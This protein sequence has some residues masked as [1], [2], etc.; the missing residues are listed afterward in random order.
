MA[1]DIDIDLLPQQE[2][3]IDNEEEDMIVSG[4]AGSGK[5]K[6]AMFKM[7]KYCLDVPGSLN[8]ATRKHGTSINFTMRDPL[9]LEL[10][11][12]HVPYNQDLT[13]NIVTLWNGTR[14]WFKSIDMLAKFRSTEFDYIWVEQAEE[15]GYY[16]YYELTMRLRGI[17]SRRQNM[18]NQ[19]ILTCTPEAESHWIYETFY[20]SGE[21][22]PI[23]FDHKQNYYLKDKFHMR[24]ER[25]KL[26]DQELYNKY[27]LGMWGKISDTIYNNWIQ[28][29]N[30]P[31]PEF[32]F[33]G[34]DWGYNNPSA[35]ILM[36]YYENNILIYNEVYK[37]EMTNTQFLNE[38]LNLLKHKGIQPIDVDMWG[39]PSEPDRMK[40]FEDAGFNMLPG[41]K[42]PLWRINTVKT[43]PILYDYSCTE[44]EKE[45]R[46]YKWEK[47]KEGKKLD[48]PIKFKDHAMDAI[49]Y[50]CVGVSEMLGLNLDLDPYGIIG[51]RSYEDLY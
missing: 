22:H 39:D 43:L 38:V 48:K 13:R 30:L 6:F 37:K 2:D 15:I 50:A 45:Y 18:F 11:R 24:L 40:E 28:V 35:F 20:E 31:K 3:Q 16:D 51:G 36:G 33:A 25:L 9:L 14:I 26:I 42:D 10:D 23:H 21:F 41:L 7:I 49:G 17:E 4:S 29:K 5:S 19:I 32:Y 47:D 44:T 12:M 1:L 27:A 46:S 8:L 34:A